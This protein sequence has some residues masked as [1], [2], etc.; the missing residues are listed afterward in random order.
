M[1][2]VYIEDRPLELNTDDISITKQIADILDLST[3]KASYTDSFNVPKTPMN[4]QVFDSLGLVGSTSRKPYEKLRA[5]IRYNG[6]DIVKDGWCQIKET[7]ENYKIAIIDGIIDFFKI[8]EN[9]SIA[10]FINL[11]EIKHYK[12]TTNVT[13]NL[14]G[15]KFRYILTDY[16]GKTTHNNKINIDHLMPSCYIPYIWDKIF[17]KTGYTYT[18]TIFN[19]ADFKNSWLTFS[20]GENKENEE[21]LVAKYS[22]PLNQKIQYPMTAPLPQWNVVESPNAEYVEND[23]NLSFKI[24]KDA[25]YKIFIRVN[26]VVFVPRLEP[27]FGNLSSNPYRGAYVNYI[28]NGNTIHNLFFYK[29]GIPQDQDYT[30]SL[31]GNVTQNNGYLLDGDV[32]SFNIQPP[33]EF[34]DDCYM[35]IDKFEVS[36]YLLDN[37]VDFSDHFQKIQVKDFFK[38]IIVR[39]GLTPIIDN[40]KKNIHFITQS[41]R[42][43]KSNAINWTKKYVQRKKETYNFGKYAQRNAF[44]HKYDKPNNAY[45]DGVITIDNKNLNDNTTLFTSFT[46]AEE[47]DKVKLL[48]N[49]L[50]PSLKMYE[51]EVKENSN[52]AVEIEYKPIK[53]RCFIIK[54]YPVQYMPVTF[55]SVGQPNQ[56]EYISPFYSLARITHLSDLIPKYYKEYA[57]ILNDL[58][59]HEIELSLSISDIL[60]LDLTAVYYFEQESSYYILNKI[61]YKHQQ[62]STAEFIKIK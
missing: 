50:L 10:S 37:Y 56:P 62:V 47:Q 58:K 16:G 33:H 52:G 38:E 2:E 34:I 43:N 55:C 36:V 28:K 30:F 12:D 18:G 54:S 35:F 29:F 22:L 15:E 5:T 57:K 8:I 21:I 26:G 59:V 19:N 14:M 40:D 61:T 4:A 48:W 49:T 45:N 20:Q 9:V 3:V 1:V 25:R 39:Y 13:N 44:A 32:I 17:E 60:N 6:I 11:E 51:K 46:Y 42:L 23:G 41:E 7:A 24:K 31:T 53:D 27:R